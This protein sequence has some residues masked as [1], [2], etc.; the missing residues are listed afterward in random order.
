MLLAAFFRYVVTLSIIEQ[1][2]LGPKKYS[3][4]LNI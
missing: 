4:I 2:F 3:N 1:A